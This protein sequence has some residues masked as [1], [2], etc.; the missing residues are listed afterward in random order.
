MLSSFQPSNENMSGK[1]SVP[2]VVDGPNF[3]EIRGKTRYW[4][5]KGGDQKWSNSLNWSGQSVPEATDFVIFNGSCVKNVVVDIHAEIKGLI[6]AADYIGCL[7]GW[8]DLIVAENVLI[9]GGIFEV[10][11]LCGGDLTIANGTL[12]TCFSTQGNLT[13][14]GGK[15]IW[16][17]GEVSGNT[18]LK[19]GL[20]KFN[21]NYTRYY[22]FKGDF[23]RAG[24]KIEGTPIFRFDGNKPQLFSA[25][26]E[27]MNLLDLYNTSQLNLQGNV[28]IESFFFNTGTLEITRA[29][30]LD[31]EEVNCFSNTGT[32]IEKGKIIRRVEGKPVR[33]KKADDLS[34]FEMPVT[35]EN[36]ALKVLDCDQTAEKSLAAIS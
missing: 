25:G 36:F 7:S 30:T 15:V 5:G 26:I 1:N 2:A 13:I 35:N 16:D 20:L 9:Q 29:G 21:S 27:E 8:N 14:S 10:S 24:G 19:G 33:H 34:T 12:K 18:I 23:I 6:I 4:N 11:L 22:S 32:L 31:L 28:K 17:S 3:R